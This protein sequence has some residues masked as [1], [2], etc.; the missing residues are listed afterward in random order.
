M[1]G[2]FYIPSSR[3]LSLSTFHTVLYL[4]YNIYNKT[5]NNSS[6]TLIKVKAL[7]NLN[8]VRVSEGYNYLND[9]TRYNH[10]STLR[11]S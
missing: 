7:A 9:I 1:C 4:F 11:E 2:Y 6:T 3:I 10:L 5:S 8:S